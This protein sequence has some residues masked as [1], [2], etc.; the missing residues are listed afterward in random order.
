MDVR[1][2]H[3]SR[4]PSSSGKRSACA[5][6]SATADCSSCST[7]ANTAGSARALDAPCNSRRSRSRRC[8]RSC[9]SAI[10]ASTETSVAKLVA[11]AW[12][13]LDV[14]TG[15]GDHAFSLLQAKEH[16]EGIRLTEHM[17]DRIA[18]P[19]RALPRLVRI[20]VLGIARD[21]AVTPIPLDR[22]A[23]ELFVVVRS[24]LDVNNQ[25]NFQR[26][27]ADWGC[28]LE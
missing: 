10:T 27:E 24:A 9:T 25:A 3:E 1:R 2:R 8:T 22:R 26:R 28:R 14:G 7:S 17:F 6:P 20:A 5:S 13:H 4:S 12:P 16:L 19:D 11:H 21:G 18:P 23:V 15:R